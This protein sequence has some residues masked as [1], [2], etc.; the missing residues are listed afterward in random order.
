MI[1]K[2]RNLEKIMTYFDIVAMISGHLII[3]MYNIIC[4]FVI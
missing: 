1:E 3:Y 2:I 4:V